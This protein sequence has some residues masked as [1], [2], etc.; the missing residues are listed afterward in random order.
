MH[1]LSHDKWIIFVFLVVP[2]VNVSG[3][4]FEENESISKF[5]LERFKM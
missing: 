4:S 5:L 1:S 2:N 3:N